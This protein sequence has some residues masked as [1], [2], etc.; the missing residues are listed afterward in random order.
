MELATVAV[1]TN[2]AVDLVRRAE[3][4]FVN[5]PI[6][7]DCYTQGRMNPNKDLSW[8]YFAECCIRDEAGGPPKES[9]EYMVP[10][11]RWSQVQDSFFLENRML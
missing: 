2:T 10:L 5:G 9:K 6:P 8:I 7:P 11:N 1:T 4:E 3:H